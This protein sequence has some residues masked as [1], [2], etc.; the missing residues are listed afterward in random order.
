MVYKTYSETGQVRLRSPDWQEEPQVDF[1]LLSDQRD[2]QRLMDGVRRF[3]A[4][5]LT[6]ILQS[7]ASSIPFPAN[8]TDRVQQTGKLSLRNKILTEALARM[9][10][11][12]RRCARLLMENLVMEG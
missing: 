4:M 8:N 5:H 3:G 2:L 9:L 11:D 7:V 1:N 12:R 10:M 6:P